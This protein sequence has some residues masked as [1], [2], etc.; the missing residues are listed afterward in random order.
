MKHIIFLLLSA[1]LLVVASSCHSNE[2][3]YR[4]AYDKAIQKKKE[5]I[6]T[7]T[8]AKIEAEQQR[9]NVAVYGDSLR[10]LRDY[11]RVI[12]GKRD[13]AKRYSVV[14]A[15]FKQVIN[16]RG[17]RDRLKSEEGFD[18]YILQRSAPDTYLVVVKG[19]DKLDV[20]A[21][22]LKNIHSYVKIKIMVAEPWVFEI[23]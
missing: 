8:L 20:A 11:A 21:A 16:A 4:Q 15:E 19:F 13:V 1:I 7:E 23:I 22:F 14:V 3:N 2:Q 6:G 17:Y 10:L 18:S 9:R 12:D 5:T